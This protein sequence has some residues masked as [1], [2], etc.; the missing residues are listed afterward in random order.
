MKHYFKYYGIKGLALITWWM[1]KDSV[2]GLFLIL[3]LLAMPGCTKENW[4]TNNIHIGDIF[5]YD[6]TQ[7]DNRPFTGTIPTNPWRVDSLAK[8]AY[9]GTDGY[10]CHS[11]NGIV[12]V[13]DPPTINKGNP[14]KV[15]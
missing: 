15:N 11:S 5:D 6:Y 9:K 2:K 10:W 3:V 8:G 14:H 12:K 13:L 7:S 1:I 4:S